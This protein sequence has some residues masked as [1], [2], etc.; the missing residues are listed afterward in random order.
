MKGT[1]AGKNLDRGF[2]FITPEG[3][4]DTKENNIFFHASALVEGLVFET[5]PEKSVVEFEVTPSDKGDRAVN[6]RLAVV[7]A[8]LAA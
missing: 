2:G 3:K 7:A 6:V 8:P 1:I 4:E 5:L